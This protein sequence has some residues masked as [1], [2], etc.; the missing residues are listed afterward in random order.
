ML[1]CTVL[2]CVCRQNSQWLMLSCCKFESRLSGE[3]MSF[4]LSPVNYSDSDSL[5]KVSCNLVILL[6]NINWKGPN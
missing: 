5:N 2:I 6:T 1:T 3:I 4:G